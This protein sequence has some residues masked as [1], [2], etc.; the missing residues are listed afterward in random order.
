MTYTVTITMSD[1]KTG[2]F[3]NAEHENVDINP[4]QCAETWLTEMVSQLNELNR[5][6]VWQ[7]YDV[8][9]IQFRPGDTTRYTYM[10]RD[11]WWPGYSEDRAT[12]LKDYQVDE[13]FLD[14]QIH[15]LSREG[16]MW[17]HVNVGN[18]RPAFEKPSAA[19]AESA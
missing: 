11:G 2:R 10:R 13:M 19:D 14:G 5:V 9:S 17:M 4:A 3:V 1:D 7:D 16:R 8:I 15:L 12:G 6:P 18:P